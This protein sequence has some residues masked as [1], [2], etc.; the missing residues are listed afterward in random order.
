MRRTLKKVMAFALVSAVAVA[1][2]ACGGNT[3]NNGDSKS[4]ERLK[5]EILYCLVV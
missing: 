5:K 3:A 1:L 4:A 2:T